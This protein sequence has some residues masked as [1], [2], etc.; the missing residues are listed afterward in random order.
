MIASSS[1][2]TLETEV[3]KT[4]GRCC[5]TSAALRPSLFACSY[6]LRAC[7]RSRISPT[8][9]REPMVIFSVSTALISGSG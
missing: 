6:S 9:T 3:V 8:I 2:I 5:S 7:S 1:G 4:F